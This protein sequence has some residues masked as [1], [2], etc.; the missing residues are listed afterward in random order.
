SRHYADMDIVEVAGASIPLDRRW[1]IASWLTLALA[2][3]LVAGAG[4]WLLVRRRVVAAGPDDAFALPDRITPLST[5]AALQ[6][7]ASDSAADPLD[8]DQRR[9]LWA[10]IA[11]LERSCF[12]PANGAPRPQPSDMQSMLQRWATAAREH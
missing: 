10:D 12:G 7:L 11:A 6:R 3:L 9:A 1:S 2:A 8:P 5:I 4:A